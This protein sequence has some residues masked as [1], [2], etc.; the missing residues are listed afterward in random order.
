MDASAEH[1]SD[2]GSHDPSSK[3]DALC[4]DYADVFEKPTGVPPERPVM[5]DIELQDNSAK[6]PKPRIYRMTHLELAKV[7]K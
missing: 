3:W 2:V 4:T 5:H 6:P 1:A 7:C